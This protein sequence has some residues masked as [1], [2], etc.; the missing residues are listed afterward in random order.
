MCGFESAEQSTTM[1]N[2]RSII[3]E[4]QRSHMLAKSGNPQ[5]GINI[6]RVRM[7]S[8][9]RVFVFIMLTPEQAIN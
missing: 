6:Q 5:R 2:G 1:R 3:K 4:L 9:G 8:I 7:K